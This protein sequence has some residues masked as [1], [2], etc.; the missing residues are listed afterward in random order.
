MDKVWGIYHTYSVPEL[1]TDNEF[2]LWEKISSL[3]PILRGI[4]ENDVFNRELDYNLDFLIYSTRKYGVE[5]DCEPSSTRRIEKSE[6][7]NKWFT[8]WENHRK[9]L[10]TCKYAEFLHKLVNN[11]DVSEYMPDTKWND[12]PKSL[13]K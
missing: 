3:E 13:I 4:E 1:Y 7:F 11:E 5:F 10:D 12:N 6:S 8:F 9:T 2:L